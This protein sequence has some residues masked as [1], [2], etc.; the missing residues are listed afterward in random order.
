MTKT[1]TN[2]INAINAAYN[3]PAVITRDQ[4]AALVSEGAFKWPYFITDHKHGFAVRRGEYTV[5]TLETTKSK[6]F[7]NSATAK[8]AIAIPGKYFNA[9][10]ALAAFVKIRKRAKKSYKG[11]SVDLSAEVKPIEVPVAAE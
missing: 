11:F 8:A 2:T 4:I 1:Q 5:P 3:N 9:D 6:Y 7:A 10:E